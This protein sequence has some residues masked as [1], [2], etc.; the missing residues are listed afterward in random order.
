VRLFVPPGVLPPPSD[1]YLLADALAAEALPPGRR[2]L[3]LGTGSGVLALAAARLG[4]ETTAI[5][6]SRRAVLAAKLNA[7]RAGVR[8]RVLRGDLLAPVAGE[9]FDAIV[10]N[11]PYLPAASDEPPARGVPRATDAGPDGRAVI[12][13]I[14]RAA[15]AHLVPGGVLLLVLSSLCGEEAV[16]RELRDGGLE[17]EVRERRRGPLGPL[18]SARAGELERRGLLAPGEREEELLVIRGYAPRS[19]ASTT[20]TPKRRSASALTSSS[21]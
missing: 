18:L 13:R 9:A 4:L 5:D 3:D 21:L 17:P 16:L 2:V 1:A 14:A 19:G 12:R 10:S 20:G 7:R 6:V 8:V 15:P 11:P